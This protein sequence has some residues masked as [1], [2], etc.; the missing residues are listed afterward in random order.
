MC[1]S[2]ITLTPSYKLLK[3]FA[4]IYAVLLKMSANASVTA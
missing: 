2:A 1:E 3:F 4:L